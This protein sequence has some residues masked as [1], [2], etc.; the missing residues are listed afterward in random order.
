MKKYLFALILICLFIFPAAGFAQEK[1]W[2]F[3]DWQV[4]IDIHKD[5][6]ISVKETHT[7]DFTGSFS[8]VKRD[9]AKQ[10]EMTIGDIKVYDGDTG[11]A[12][13]SKDYSVTEGYYSDTVQINFDLQNT[14]KKYIIE[15]DVYNAIGYFETWDE[16]YWNAVSDDRDVKI[17][18]VDVWVNL[19]EE[20]NKDEMQATLYEGAYSSNTASDTWEIID[21]KTYHYW[22]NNIGAY[23]NFTIVAGWPKGIVREPDLLKITSTPEDASIYRNNIDTFYK[24]PYQFYVGDN[25]E[26]GTEEITV[27]KFGHIDQTKQ[28]V[29]EEGSGVQYLDFILKRTV[30]YNILTILIIILIASWICSP[31]LILFLLLRKWFKIGRDPKGR[32]TIIPQYKPYK[33]LTPG[34]TGTLI[35]AKADLR[36]IT[37]T[38]I[39]LAVRGYIKII[40]TDKKKFTLKKLKNSDSNLLDYE[41]ELF[42]GIFGSSKE[43][44]LDDLKHKFYKHIPTI[45]TDMYELMVSLKF[46]NKDPEKIRKKYRTWGILLTAFGFFGIWAYGLGLPLFAW[47]ILFFIFA[48]LMPGRTK[49][50]VEG[51]EWSDGYEMYLHHAERYRLK[52]MTPEHFEASLPYAMVFKVEKEWAKNFEKIYK[53]APSWFEPYPG[54]MGTWSSIYFVSMLSSS[55]NPALTSTLASRP[56]GSYSGG[57]ASSGMSGFSGG[58][59]SGGGFG[60]GG[61][62]AG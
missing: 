17:D 13:S 37:S 32:G 40:Q 43:K 6:S 5:S 52:K 12:L 25:I 44:D 14:E 3:K 19:P 8:W 18:Q 34:L 38:I 33:K 39:D 26:Y 62:S 56:G 16:L 28:V 7:Y 49:N 24:T 2:Y 42:K 60:G 30:W 47:G 53:Q 21:N 22:G 1:S 46:F 57:G 36:D 50:G 31:L 51:K 48:P 23:E 29:I 58:G 10:G 45:R 20:V 55:F 61:S 4:E 11:E 59:F 27:K 15:Y 54:A 35:D 9:I 41:K